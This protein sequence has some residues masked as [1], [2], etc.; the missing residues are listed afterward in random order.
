MS[1]TRTE[2][3]ALLTPPLH[4]I[5][6]IMAVLPS[7]MYALDNFEH[8]RLRA[9]DS[10]SFESRDLFSWLMIMKSFVAVSAS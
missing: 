3:Q 2:S 9:S 1:V 5:A 8:H 10:R 7:E 6:T 4:T